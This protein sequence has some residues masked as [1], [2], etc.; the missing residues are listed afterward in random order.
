MSQP[1]ECRFC[2]EKRHHPLFVC[3]LS[4]SRYAN[5]PSLHTTLSWIGVTCNPFVYVRSQNRD[6]RFIPGN[7]LTK[8]GAPHYQIEMVCGP[9]QPEHRQPSA[10]EMARICRAASRKL[11]NRM[12][13]FARYA[14]ALST[15]ESQLDGTTP[16][17]QLYVRD[18]RLVEKYCRADA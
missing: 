14:Q 9:F 7:Q 11:V 5:N 10:R 6:S 17:P 1:Y 15:S 8:A 13:F 12:R 16:A 2:I 4:D 18:K 3:L